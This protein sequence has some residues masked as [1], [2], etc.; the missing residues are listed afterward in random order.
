M[1]KPRRVEI[2]QKKS[3]FKKFI[4]KIEEAQFRYEK[5]DGD[6]SETLTRLSLERGDSVAALIHN[7]IEDT[8]LLAEQF[9]YSTYGKGQ[10]WLLEVVA[11]MVD[12]DEAPSD[13][14]RREITEEIGYAVQVLHKINAFYLSPGG[15]SERIHLFYAS[16]SRDDRVAK[17]GGVKYEGED[18][19]TVML[20]TDEALKKMRVDEL[21]DAK[22][23]IALQWFELNRDNLPD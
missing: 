21:P 7:R 1:N 15:S 16:V 2:I 17:G 8:L 11:G 10:G 4:F 14:M 19:R 13:A 9:R 12:G 3:V 6:M 18:I 20:K 5:F 23:L 22:T